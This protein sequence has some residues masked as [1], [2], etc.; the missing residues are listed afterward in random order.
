MTIIARRTDPAGGGQGWGICLEGTIISRSPE[1]GGRRQGER[2]KQKPP[3]AV[4]VVIGDWDWWVIV[5]DSAEDG[6]E[7]VVTFSNYMQM[8]AGDYSPEALN[9]GI[10]TRWSR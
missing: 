4:I 1:L 9:H 2:T 6:T 5:I 8:S 7:C 10:L 3:K